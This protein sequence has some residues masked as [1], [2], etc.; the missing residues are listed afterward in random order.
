M[1]IYAIPCKENAISELQC[2]LKDA[3]DA[4]WY[5]RLKIVQLSMSGKTV[6]QLADEFDLC[7]ATVR[8]YIKAYN[9]GGWQNLR[10][11][12]SPGRPTK[13]GH[14]AQ[15]DWRDI[16][17]QTPNQYEK[18]NTDSRQWTLELLVRYAKEYLGEEVVFQTISE[19]LRRCQFRTGRSKLRVASPDPDYGVKRE[20]VETL[21]SLPLRG[22]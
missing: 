12:K 4:K 13:V 20:R 8:S 11:K 19:A 22:N 10:A 14:L 9:A 17:S 2:A 15:D 7:R 1:M 18:L 5:R 6:A 3:K 21:R 16:L